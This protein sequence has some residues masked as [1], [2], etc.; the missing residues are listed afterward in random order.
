MKHVTVK[1]DTI[2]RDVTMATTPC[3]G[4][5]AF[6]REKKVVTGEQMQPG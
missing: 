1:T 2:G 6:Q 5:G 3:W 4:R